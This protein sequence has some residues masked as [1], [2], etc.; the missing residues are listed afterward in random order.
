MTMTPK[1]KMSFQLALSHCLLH[2]CPCSPPAPVPGGGARAALG[3]AAA[4]ASTAAAADAVRSS[5]PPSRPP[6]SRA[7]QLREK[8]HY[9]MRR[10]P[11]TNFSWETCQ[12]VLSSGLNIFGVIFRGRSSNESYM[13]YCLAPPRTWC[14]IGFR[15]RRGSGDW[16]W[17]A[18]DATARPPPP[19]GRRDGAR[20]RAPARWAWAPV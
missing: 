18:G 20:L 2:V 19:R 7:P 10:L 9:E 15:V 11:R 12:L 6:G 16:R 14:W 8:H 5:A 3:G 1:L 17:R 13:Q 4:A